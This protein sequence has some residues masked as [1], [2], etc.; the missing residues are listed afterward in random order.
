MMSRW[1]F[2]YVDLGTSTRRNFLFTSTSLAAAAFWAQRAEGAVLSRLKTGDD[3][4]KLGVASGDPTPDG[5]VIWTRLAPDP[6]TGGGMPNEPVAVTWEVAED[7]QFTKTVQFGKT[8]AIPAWAH[9]VHVEV[10]GLKPDRW[11]FYRFRVGMDESRIGRARTFPTLN[12]QVDK[13]KFAFASCQH[14]ESGLFTAYEH[15]LRDDLDLVVHLGDYLYEGPGKDNLVRKHVGGKLDALEDYRNRHAQYKTDPHL[16][17]MHAAA[18]WL[19]TW[20]DHEFENNCAGA[21]PELRKDNRPSPST[22]DYLAMRARAYQ[23]YYEHMPLRLSALPNGPDMQLYRRVSFGRLANFCVLD[24][25]QYRSDQPHGDGR[26]PQ[27]DEALSLS[28]TLLG[29]RQEAWLKDALVGSTAKWNVL[30]QQVMMARVDRMPGEL[31]AFSMDQWPGYEMNRRRMLKFFHE[32]KIANPVVL[33]GDIHSNWA[34]DLICDFDKL[35]SCV[36]ASEFVG[37]SLS[38]GGNGVDKPK[39]HTATLA[40]NPFVKFFNT[41]RGYVRCDLSAKEWRSDY[42]V[43]TEVLKPGGQMLTRASFVVEAGRPGVQKA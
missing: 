8:T 39:D 5:F 4:F 6:L 3:P 27:G 32:R 40:E 28:Q 17:A 33:T 25:R 36:V 20:D 42:Q 13:L 37:T 21:V 11:Y 22:R 43:V 31:A 2:P 35:D 7:E 34:N 23:A 38:S 1:Q 41:E 14:F 12:A 18:P 30:A 19:V 9:S 26:K 10:A 29:D 16:Q 24:T 15:M